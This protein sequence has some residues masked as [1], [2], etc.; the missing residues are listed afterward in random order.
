MSRENVPQ[1]R[2]AQA[3]AVVAALNA[4]DF[5]A[6]GDLPFHPDLMFRSVLAVAEG[7][8]Y[9]G[10]EG[11]REWARNVDST[12]DDFRVELVEFREV[13][14]E[15]AVSVVRTAGRAKASGLPITVRVGQVW[16]W[17]NGLIWRNDAYTDVR[18][19]FAAVGLRE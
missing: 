18:E 4:R 16:T 11:L 12:F 9:H 8:V 3:E 14:A 5:D 19:A 2:R 13:D 17:R 6:L 1:D 10:I 7:D 15:R